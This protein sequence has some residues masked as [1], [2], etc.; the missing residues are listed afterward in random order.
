MKK[1]LFMVLAAFFMLPY[2]VMAQTVRQ[3]VAVYMTGD[4]S[5]EGY[6]K[7][8]GS[9][10][11]SEIAKSDE[12]IAV[13]RT[14]DFL[15]ALSSEQDYQTSG[16]VR[17]NQIVQIG[18]KFGVRY[19]AVV[20]ISEVFEELFIAARLIDVQ[21]GQIDKSYETSSRVASMSE[22]TEL[23]QNVAGG[24]I[25]G[26]SVSGKDKPF[27]MALAV[28]KEGKR[29]YL[30]AE[31]WNKMNETQKIEYKKLGLVIM[32]N[33]EGFIMSL[34]T[35]DE[36]NG[37]RRDDF[38]TVSQFHIIAEQTDMIV[39]TLKKMNFYIPNN[40]ELASWIN[41]PTMFDPILNRINYTFYYTNRSGTYT[42][43]GYESSQLK[44]YLTIIPLN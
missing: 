3:K 18:Q 43:I 27:P 38:P 17:D 33:G 39:S 24:M 36:I 8:I 7:V 9:K 11:V 22:L 28:E 5:N 4:I 32:Q 19:V 14:A 21:T 40:N 15:K 13:E 30:T 42:P 41:A 6:K 2:V 1:F 23:A 35:S 12:Y 34:P 31:Q 10:M 26:G 20:D 16:E 37:Q 25:L 29:Y 44:K